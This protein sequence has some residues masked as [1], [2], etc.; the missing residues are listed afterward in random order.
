MNLRPSRDQNNELEI[1]IKKSTKST[2]HL[3][4]HFANFALIFYFNSVSEIHLT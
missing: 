3:P 2:L 1:T 4:T